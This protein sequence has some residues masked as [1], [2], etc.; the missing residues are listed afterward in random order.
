M[1]S[2]YERPRV[3][4]VTTDLKMT[5]SK[6]VL[7]D[8]ACGIDRSRFDPHVLL[9][10]PVPPED[11]LRRELEAAGVPVHHVPARARVSPRGLKALSRWIDGDGRPDLFHTHC[12]RSAGIVRLCVA[13]RRRRG[14]PAVVV[15]FH[16]TV[17]RRA[18]RPTNRVLDRLLRPVTDLVLAPTA[19]AAARGG[20]AHAY[21]GLRA[22]IVHNG[23]DLKRVARALRPASEVR[24]AWG[25]PQDAR[26]VLLLGRWDAAKGHD[27]LL[28]AIP[29]VLAHPEPVRF[30]LVAP[31]GGGSYRSGLERLVR[32][33]AL[34]RFVVMTGRDT[35]P[36]SCYAAADVVAM[37]SRDEPFGLVAVEAMGAGRSLVVARAGGLPEV[38]GDEDA[39]VWVPPD[40]PLALGRAI[41]DVLGEDATARAARGD[42]ARARAARFALPAYLHHLESAYAD[43]LDRPDLRPLGPEPEGAVDVDWTRAT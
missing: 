2:P 33:T 32:D 5:G 16:G 9:F 23:V 30:V 25:V 39:V 8:G 20:S 36:G 34:R 13:L 19:A 41:L 7:V 42:R 11:P 12:A 1:S 18:L 37:P 27:V 29:L 6:R 24:R 21:R 3:V 43:A 40:D 38:C 17:S 26:V 14:R 35:D 22:R 4:A 15:H 31:E 28:D 10:S